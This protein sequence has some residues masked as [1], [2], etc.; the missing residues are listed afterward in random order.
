MNDSPG[1]V[2]T[3]NPRAPCGALCAGTAADVS[4]DTTSSTAPTPDTR[5][6]LRM[7]NPS[8]TRFRYIPGTQT[9][10][11]LRPLAT[12]ASPPDCSGWANPVANAPGA[13]PGAVVRRG[14]A[15]V[16]SQRGRD[17][18]AVPAGY[19][20]L[21]RPGAAAAHL[22]GPVPAAGPGPDG[23]PGPAAVR[24]DGDQ[25]GPRDRGGRRVGT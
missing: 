10:G 6:N 17:A 15:D 13:G 4:A 24:R 12:P 21:P 7:A 1:A 14:L 16:V 5:S 11:Q 25:G 9:Y 18:A 22:R 8:S 20:A 3:Q 23:G 19:G 2:T